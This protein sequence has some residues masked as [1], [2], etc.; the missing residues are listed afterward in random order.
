MMHLKIFFSFID[1][2]GVTPV[3]HGLHEAQDGSEY[4]P[5]QNCKFT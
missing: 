3:A 1:L 2:Q 4:S 5:T